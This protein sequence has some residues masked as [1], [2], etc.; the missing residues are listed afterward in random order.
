MQIKRSERPRK[1]TSLW[2]ARLKLE[3]E[4]QPKDSNHLTKSLQATIFAQSCI[5]DAIERESAMPREAM[6]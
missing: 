3:G 5:A 1:F 2:K 6:S 4:S